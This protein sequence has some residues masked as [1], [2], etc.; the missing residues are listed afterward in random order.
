MAEEACSVVAF[1]TALWARSHNMV[2]QHH[3]LH[4]DRMNLACVASTST[5]NYCRYYKMKASPRCSRRLSSGCTAQ[6]AE[7]VPGSSNF[8]A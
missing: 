4:R 3:L 6:C 2:C 1:G 8:P 7:G 5:W